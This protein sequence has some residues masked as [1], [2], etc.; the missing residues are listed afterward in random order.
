MGVFCEAYEPGTDPYHAGEQATSKN[1]GSGRY[2]AATDVSHSP[3]FH[4]VE[5]LVVDQGITMADLKGTLAYLLVKCSVRILE[6]VFAPASFPSA[7]PS[8]EVD[9]SCISAAGRAVVFAVIAVGL[10]TLGCGMVDPAVFAAVDL[11]GEDSRFCLWDG[12]RTDCNVAASHRYTF[13]LRFQSRVLEQFA[14][15]DREV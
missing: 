3:M 1:R 7:E 4:R 9:V 2:I 8:A 11:D 12:Y 15:T 5:G 13:A 10:R 14:Q 6:F